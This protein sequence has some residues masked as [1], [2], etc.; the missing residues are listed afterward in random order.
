[1]RDWKITGIFSG[2]AFLLSL[3]AGIAG[4]V[5]FGSILLR[6]SIGGIAFGVLAFLLSFIIRK[7]LPELFGDEG[8]DSAVNIEETAGS[9]VDIVIDDE[10]VVSTDNQT[11]MDTGTM[12]EEVPV[13]SNNVAEEEPLDEIPVAAE[14]GE[15]DT[16]PNIETFSEVFDSA[17]ENQDARTSLTGSVSVDIMGQE[18]D[19]GT[20]A[21]AIRTIMHKDQEG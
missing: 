14:E 1:M 11:E 8:S 5:S 12:E 7:F 13:F 17:T 16:L 2:G 18:E 3:I 4:R 15:S 21:K 9:N 19:P 6:A 10:E 20:V